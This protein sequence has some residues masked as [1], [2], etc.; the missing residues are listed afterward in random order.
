MSSYHI[1]V[2]LQEV[3]E[4]LH[5]KRGEKYIDATLGGGGHSLEIIKQGGLVLGIDVDQ[6][7]I[8]YVKQQIH[9]KNYTIGKELTIG[10]GNFK[11]IAKLAKEN[12]FERVSGVLFD[13]GVSSFQLDTGNKGFSFM[14]SGPLD[15]RMD[16]NLQVSAAD[17]VNGLT[18]Q[19]LSDIFVR[20]GEERNAKKIAM[21]IVL[22]R[23]KGKIET[24]EQLVKCIEKAFGVTREIISQKR[25]IEMCMRVFQ[26]LRIAVNDELG[27]IRDAL[28]K[29]LN[30]LLP[31]GRLVVIS[32]HSLEDRIVKQTFLEFEKKGYGKIV[33]KK[34]II[35]SASEVFVNR[36][37][38]SAKMRI[39][40]KM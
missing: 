4:A 16:Q 9:S 34:P 14:Q 35:A 20:F 11:D 36:R 17:L 23:E 2:L 18:K 26:A 30:V 10:R 21:E 38:R 31:S 8:T 5:I 25:R 32:F 12:G 37:S 33:T 15:M 13:L 40:E 6:D 7:A 39:F 1:P 22:E 24:T 28:P 3:L 19:E 29:A 27:V